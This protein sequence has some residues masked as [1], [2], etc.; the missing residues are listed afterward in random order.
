[1]RFER[2]CGGVCHL[3]IFCCAGH[4]VVFAFGL[5]ALEHAIEGF[6][7]DIVVIIVPGV[8]GAADGREFFLT[9]GPSISF[10]K[11]GRLGLWKATCGLHT[12]LV[13]VGIPSEV[14]DLT[15]TSYDAKPAYSTDS[16]LAVLKKG[17]SEGLGGE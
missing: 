10:G 8:D 15:G 3:R 14:A 12:D 7:E 2:L 1:M 13:P 9:C 5:H 17:I 16:P 4:S 6:F 11:F